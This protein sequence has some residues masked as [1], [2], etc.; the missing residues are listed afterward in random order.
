MKTPFSRSNYFNFVSTCPRP[1]ALVAHRRIYIYASSSALGASV[2]FSSNIITQLE[3]HPRARRTGPSGSW[4]F[5][6]NHLW[7][8]S[9]PRRPQSSLRGLKLENDPSYSDICDAGR[10][11]CI[12]LR[13]LL[14]SPS[15]HI[16]TKGQARRLKERDR[17]FTD[18]RQTDHTVL[19]LSPTKQRAPKALI[20]WCC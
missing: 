13:S 2:H 14:L 7:R 10:C 16:S 5:R 4:Y 11:K 12:T 1:P 18:A 17:L 19:F 8:R 15:A 6:D 9:W 3:V 20:Q